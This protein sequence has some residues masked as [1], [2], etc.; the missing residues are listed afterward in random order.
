MKRNIIYR[1]YLFYRQGGVSVTSLLGNVL[2]KVRK[3]VEG[4]TLCAG[5][6]AFSVSGFPSKTQLRLRMETDMEI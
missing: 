6:S 2:L 1:D 4:P 3:D 5:G